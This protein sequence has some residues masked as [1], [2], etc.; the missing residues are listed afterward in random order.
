MNNGFFLFKLFLFLVSFFLNNG[1]NSLYWMAIT[2]SCD[3]IL[4]DTFS[5]VL[6]TTVM[7]KRCA[8]D[9]SRHQMLPVGDSGPP[10]VP[11]QI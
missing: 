10:H 3:L 9:C 5:D 4:R 8:G 2:L 11:R 6:Q 7:R 1:Q